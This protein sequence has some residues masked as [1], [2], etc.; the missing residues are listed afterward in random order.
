MNLFWYCPYL[1]FI[2][3]NDRTLCQLSIG[4]IYNRYALMHSYPAYTA[5]PFCWTAGFMHSLPT[6]EIYPCLCTSVYISI[7][8]HF[9]HLWSSDTRTQNDS[10]VRIPLYLLSL[11]FPLFPT[12][13]MHRSTLPRFVPQIQPDHDTGATGDGAEPAG[14]V[15]RTACL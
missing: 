3:P 7:C 10:N 1:M 2:N 11:F 9:R 4:N 13:A 12:L 8:F 5:W 6:N 15:T 14:W